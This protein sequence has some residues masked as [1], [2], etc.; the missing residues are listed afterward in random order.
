MSSK[1]VLSGLLFA[2]LIVVVSSCSEENNRPKVDSDHSPVITNRINVSN[3]IISNLG[4]TFETVTSGKLGSWITVPG[5]IEVPREHRYALV[6][7]TRGRIFWVKERLSTLAKGDVLAWIESPALSQVQQ[8][9]ASSVQGLMTAQEL[10]NGSRGAAL[11]QEQLIRQYRESLGSLAILTGYSSEELE[12]ETEGVP[13]WSS[14]KQLQI[15]ACAAGVLLEVSAADGEIIDEGTALGRIVDVSRPVFRGLVSSDLYP[16][17]PY[18]ALVRIENTGGLHVE[19]QLKGP[20]PLG[21]TT[22]SKVWL[23]A[24]LAETSGTFVDGAAVL[25]H[26][27]TASSDYEEALVPECCIVYDNLHAV[28]FRRD[29][30]DS[31]HVIRTVVEIGNRAGGRV[32]VVSGVMSGDQIVRDGVHQLKQ[33]AASAPSAQGHFHADG[34]WHEGD[35]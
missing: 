23:E 21:D 6:A 9:L 33:I 5:K 11:R 7:P 18:R 17:I 4:I 29:P 31:N 16:D 1:A 20:L 19:T 25:A 22:T 13:L 26:I 24:Q 15:R 12:Q 2:A 32:E 34:T 3:A 10:D 35:Q 8:R 28:V 30:L 27:Q 14:L